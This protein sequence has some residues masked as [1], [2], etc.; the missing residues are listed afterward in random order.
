MAIRFQTNGA[1]P[2]V[3]K[4]PAPVPKSLPVNDVINTV[5]DGPRPVN[6]GVNDAD[7][8]VNNVIN[9]VNDVSRAEVI[10]T[11]T[12]GIGGSAARMRRYREAHPDAYRKYM[13]DYM[14][15]RRSPPASA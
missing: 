2:E 1:S 8:P 11:V 7:C 6:D 9:G 14:R 15:R 13:R 3:V 4:L 12:K 10:S 5:N